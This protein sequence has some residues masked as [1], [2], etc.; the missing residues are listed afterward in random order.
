[1]KAIK[2]LIDGAAKPAEA[3]RPLSPE[4]ERYEKAVAGGKHS[5]KELDNLKAFA[6]MMD[7]TRAKERAGQKSDGKPKAKPPEGG[8]ITYG[9]TTGG[10]APRAVGRCFAEVEAVPIRW[11]WPGRIACGKLTLLA[12]DPGLGKSQITAA[13]AATVTRGGFWPVDGTRCDLPGSVVFLSAEDDAADTMKPRLDAVGADVFKCHILDAI[14]ET[15]EAGTQRERYF[16]LKSDLLRLAHFVRDI[17]D[18]RLIVIDP[19]SAY[20]GGVDSHKNADVRALLQPMSEVAEGLG[21]AILGVSHLNKS[22]AQEA[23]QRIS[24]SLA[25]VAAARAALIVIKD[26]ANPARR[27]LLPLKNNLGRDTGGLAF[28]VQ[29]ITLESG[30]ETSR[31]EWE[32]DPVNISADDAMRTDADPDKAG[33][34]EEARRF[35]LDLLKDGPAM[36]AEAERECLEAGF[37]VRTLK[38]AKKDLGIVSEKTAEGWCWAVSRDDFK[39]AN[40]APRKNVGTL[41]TLQAGRGFQPEKNAVFGQEC[42]ANDAGTLDRTQPRTPKNAAS[43]PP[44]EEDGHATETAISMSL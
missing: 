17:G 11:L 25:F 15:D 9:R 40:T 13:M 19:I 1:M 30:L 38:R 32:P 43:N 7:K 14:L 35:L 27:L 6:E 37:S 28:S 39:S 4:W 24:G 22:G 23:M 36:A 8:A 26:K 12:G 16:S 21:V 33:E 2:D 18:V 42:Q 5:P 20:L 41:G 3:K 34:R 31:V 10:G 29:S 44:D